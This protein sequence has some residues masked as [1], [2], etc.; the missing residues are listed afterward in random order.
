VPIVLPVAADCPEHLLCLAFGKTLGRRAE[1][2]RNQQVL[3]FITV[4]FRD[5]LSD[6]CHAILVEVEEWLP[7]ICQF[8]VNGSEYAGLEDDDGSIASCDLVVWVDF[9]LDDIGLLQKHDIHGKVISL[10]QLLLMRQF[11]SRLVSEF[12]KLLLE[13]LDIL[14]CAL[15]FI[16]L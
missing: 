11:K 9:P 1:V 8:F 15:F 13:N 2:T 6:D 5:L 16:L 10:H 3:L 12:F 14:R 4:L 7:H